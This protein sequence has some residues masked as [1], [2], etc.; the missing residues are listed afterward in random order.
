MAK[1]DSSY[2]DEEIREIASRPLLLGYRL[3]TLTNLDVPPSNTYPDFVHTGDLPGCTYMFGRENA[4]FE[5]WDIKG[6]TRIKH[7]ENRIVGLLDSNN[8]TNIDGSYNLS[9]LGNN[10]SI[11]PTA[12]NIDYIESATLLKGVADYREVS[13]TN[14]MNFPFTIKWVTTDTSQ[15]NTVCAS[16]KIDRQIWSNGI[17]EQP[18]YYSNGYN[19]IFLKWCAQTNGGEIGDNTVIKFT[20]DLATTTKIGAQHS[21]TCPI[22]AYLVPNETNK[23]LFG[24]S[25]FD[26]ITGDIYTLCFNINSKIVSQLNALSQ[27]SPLD[28][29]SHPLETILYGETGGFFNWEP[30]N[31]IITSSRTQALKY[32]DDG[33]IPSDAKIKP[34]DPSQLPT[35][36]GTPGGDGGDDG[37]GSDTPGENG[38]NSRDTDPT[39]TVQ[40]AVT[41]LAMTPNNLYWIQAGD[42]TAFIDWFWEDVGQITDIDDLLDKIKGL[43]A[44]LASTILN[45]RYMPINPSWAGSTMQTVGINVG[46]ITCPGNYTKFLNASPRIED[47]GSINIKEK[48]ESFCDYSP[49]SNMLL[50]LPFHGMVEL[51]N[52]FFM[53]Q[54]LSVKAIYDIMSGTIQYF[55]F[56]GDVM[57]N[58]FIAQMAV[59]IPITLQSKAD[60]DS[61]IFSNVANATANTI[62]AGFSA[63]AGNPIGLIMSTTAATQGGQNSA[64]YKLLSTQGETGA[65]YAPQRCAIYI[66]RPSYN[67][68]KNY[69]ARVGFPCNK[70]YTL[71]KLKGFTT[72]YNP[73]IE[74]THATKPLQSEIDEIY[75]LLEKGVIL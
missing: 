5:F 15:S 34:L 69:G 25:V 30:Y 12:A 37:D 39:P 61:A 73:Y 56:C 16:Q 11:Q 57:T 42:L 44:D 1:I 7:G 17:T 64:P 19:T 32:L 67:R 29:D 60:R 52:D 26:Q 45:V 65:F 49:Y 63:A 48:Y 70:Q 24:E 72:C 20:R 47:I 13:G 51:D 62:G 33:T 75:S 54:T 55:I 50:Y 31:L 38:D 74:F 8:P 9:I 66:R 36:D 6:I 68:P 35:T 14:Y 18:D 59:D 53:G 2:T 40:P 43:Y 4:N 71:E 21:S 23:Q 46:M 41:P 28:F 22:Q 58:S 27:P 3:P 10:L